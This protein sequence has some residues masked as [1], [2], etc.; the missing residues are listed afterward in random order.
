[1]ANR[2][3]SDLTALTAPATGDL[4]PIV[5]ISEAAAADKNKKITYG[6]LLSSAP[7]GSAAAPSFS[8][9]GDP[10]SGLYS[11][12]ADQV[13]ISTNSS[14][15]LVVDA[16]GKVGVGISPSALMH[17]S[18][19]YAT[20]STGG[21]SANTRLIVSNNNAVS[22][23]ANISLLYRSNAKGRL[24]FGNQLVEDVAYI[25]GGVNYLAF[26]AGLG[27]VSADERLRITSAGLVGV[28]TSSPGQL[29][30]IRAAA[31]GGAP[32]TSGTTQNGLLRISQTSV[33]QSLDIGTNADS[34]SWLQATNRTDL[35]VKYPLAINPNGGNV[36][37]GTSTPG[38]KLE[39]AGSAAFRTDADV[40]L[41]IGSSGSIGSN[42]SNFIRA[43]TD[44]V[45]YNAATSSGRHSWE[46]AGSEKARIDSSGRLGIG[47][48][49]PSYLLDANGEARIATRLRIDGPSSGDKLKLTGITTGLIYSE[50]SN[51]GNTTIFGNEQSTGGGLCS[52]GLAYATVVNA[53]AARP[54][55]LATS[56][57]A[58]LT[59]D[60]SGRV[61]IG[62]TSPG[63]PLHIKVD[64]AAT[65]NI[66]VENTSSGSGA[67]AQFRVAGN[68]GIGYFG[69]AGSGSGGT[70]LFEADYVYLVSENNASG[71]NLG[72]ASGPLRFFSQNSERGRFDA[73]G[74]LLVG[75]S[76]SS[77]TVTAVFSGN[78]A[79]ADSAA[80]EFAAIEVQ[81]DAAP[82]AS[83]YPGRLVFSVTRDGQASPTE[84][85]R[86]GNAGV[87]QVYDSSSNGFNV[88]TESPSGTGANLFAGYYSATS[89]TTGTNCFVVYANG[90]VQNTNNSYGALS[91][92]KLKENIVDAN[93]QWDD[94]K[95]LQVRNYN[96]KEGQTH[97]QIGLVAQEVEL[98]SPGS[99]A[100]HLTATMKATT[101]APSPR[102]STI[103]CS[104]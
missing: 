12:G 41:T 24:N 91:D 52:G 32:A 96:F 3:I 9:D 7:A 30:E 10:N 90:N 72:A 64:Q 70:N 6:E 82:G 61:G 101:L 68:S 13:A 99:S 31:S 57:T 36:G 83:D 89:T 81:A 37:I 84:R 34:Y 23:E 79:G 18:S 35:S 1:M 49:S 33:G 17:V 75:T 93:S 44:Q 16:S 60:S 40:R 38:T 56:N 54:L 51:T 92:L 76:T 78:S 43:A 8:F 97:T 5:D 102:A 20:P 39:V 42:N 87:V 65:T 11:A 53:Q 86:I 88:R 95:A 55:Q 46:L 25:E 94:L 22:S 98:V 19:S 48:S 59:I 58:R 104:T 28:G 103:R 66:A 77:A 26:G 21:I 45:I 14:Q 4:L 80:G 15:R 67:Y 69:Y 74:R 47:T 71:L 29:L 50:I 63:Y 100:N 62:T 2:K 85:L 73:S 27:S